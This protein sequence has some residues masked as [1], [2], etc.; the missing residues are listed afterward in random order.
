MPD[1]PLRMIPVKGSTRQ[2]SGSFDFA[3]SAEKEVFIDLSKKS[4]KANIVRE[5][6][7]VP[8]TRI[9]DRELDRLLGGLRIQPPKETP[10]VVEQSLRPGQ[11]VPAGTAV[12]LVL[13]STR[14]IPLSIFEGA[15]ADLAERDLGTFLEQTLDKEE[16]RG[17][18]RIVLGKES[19]EDLSTA[20]RQEVEQM[21]TGANVEIDDT[22]VEKN[23]DS[24]YRLLRYSAAYR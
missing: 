23:L 15:H 13:I 6:F 19:S 17:A 5:G 7:D 3:A 8:E 10:R 16:N 24:A 14:D 1:K 12:D 20:E 9:I 18:L 11:K 4:K 21:L 22:D 2:L